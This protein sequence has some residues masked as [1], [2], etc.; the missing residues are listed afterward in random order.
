MEKIAE[1]GNNIYQCKK[2]GLAIGCKSTPQSTTTCINQNY[3]S[4]TKIAEKGDNLY[5]CRKCGK[6]LKCKSTP[7]STTTCENRSYHSWHKI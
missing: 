1:D 7:Q 6:T 4:W 5:E 2:C 3:H